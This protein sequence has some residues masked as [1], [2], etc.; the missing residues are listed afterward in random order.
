MTNN[1]IYVMECNVAFL[2]NGMGVGEW[3]V[4]VGRCLFFVFLFSLIFCFLFIFSYMLFYFYFFLLL[5]LYGLQPA[6][7]LY[8]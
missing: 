8:I 3:V 5:L 2:C 6:F 4:R 7:L 1:N